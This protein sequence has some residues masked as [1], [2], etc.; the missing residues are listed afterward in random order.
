MK[1]ILTKIAAILAFIIGAMAVFAGAQ[2]LLGNDPGY[3][4]INWVPVYNYTA[5]IL[6]VFITAIL[7]WRGSKLAWLAAI[8]TFSL[9]TLVMI[10]LQTVHRD[11]V[12]VDSIRAMTIRMIAWAIILVL[13]FAQSQKDKKALRL[14]TV[15]KS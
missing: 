13:M 1:S 10:L 12:A 5:G 14:T 2:V 8:A 4:V 3:Y 6:T 9:H 15:A 7:I 11:V